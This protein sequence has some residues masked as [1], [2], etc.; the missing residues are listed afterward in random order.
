MKES[1]NSLL[2]WKKENRSP[3]E[4]LKQT[5][6][7]L[8]ELQGEE[9]VWDVE[10]IRAFQAKTDEIMEA[11]ELKWKQRA[12]EDWLKHRDKNSKFFHASVNQKRRGNKISSII[13][14]RGITC[15]TLE[16]VEE[17]FVSYFCGILATSYPIGVNELLAV[18]S[19]RIT[20]DMN[21][22]L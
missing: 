8:L 7:R 13:N 10:D 18:L 22:D 19:R 12:K 3:Y 16:S 6:Q 14:E 9:E 4:V 21:N 15:A 5:T 1:E 17:A 2:K 11:D 20:M